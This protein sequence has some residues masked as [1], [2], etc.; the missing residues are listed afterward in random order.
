ML[1][2]GVTLLFCMVTVQCFNIYSYDTRFL[3][4]LCELNSG[5]LQ[6]IKCTIN[7]PEMWGTQ[8]DACVPANKGG[9]KRAS[10]PIEQESQRVVSSCVGAGNPSQVL[11]RDSQC[12]Q[13][14]SHL[15]SPRLRFWWVTE[16][17]GQR[18][19]QVTC[20]GTKGGAGLGSWVLSPGSFLLGYQL[21]EHMKA[22]CLRIS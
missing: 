15:S 20:A 5:H 9:Q 18:E 12:S 6:G 4:S 19:G 21:G 8:S 3:S 7:N 14:L 11:W 17:A 13:E 10:D 16:P 2:L 1:T 22:L